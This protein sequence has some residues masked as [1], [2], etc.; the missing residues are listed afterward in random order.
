MVLMNSRLLSQYFLLQITVEHMEIMQ[1]FSFV[2]E[3]K[4]ILRHLQRIK[5][6]LLHYQNTR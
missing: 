6:N 5:T 1:Q 4:L 3:K 2:M